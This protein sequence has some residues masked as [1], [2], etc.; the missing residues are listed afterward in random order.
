MF[1]E[2]KRRYPVE[3]NT[4]RGVISYHFIGIGFRQLLADEL[5]LPFFRLVARL[6]CDAGNNE[7][8]GGW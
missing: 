8:H 4:S 5:I 7:R 6:V 3:E 2:S 1:E